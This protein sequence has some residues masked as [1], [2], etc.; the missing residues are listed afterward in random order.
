[1]AI[2]EFRQSA[3]IGFRVHSGWGRCR[4][5]V[6]A[7]GQ[8]VVVDRRKNSAVKTFSYTFRQPYHTRKNGAP[9]VL[10]VYFEMCKTE[11]KG[12]RYLVALAAGANGSG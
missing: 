2:G 11:A 12:L 8:P 5:C 10:R 9:R 7:A 6:W 4:R 1:M 3:A